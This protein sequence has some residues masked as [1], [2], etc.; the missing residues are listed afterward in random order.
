MD[1]LVYV[2]ESSSPMLRPEAAPRTFAPD[3]SL[4]LIGIRGCRS[5]LGSSMVRGDGSIGL[6]R[7]NERHDQMHSRHRIA[8]VILT[9]LNYSLHYPIYYSQHSQQSCSSL[10]NLLKISPHYTSALVNVRNEELG[11]CRIVSGKRL[12]HQIYA[13]RQW[14]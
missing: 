8:E 14:S 2:K 9:S 3:A 4:V 12:F 10:L 11:G 5:G 13:T 1:Q 6:C 7:V